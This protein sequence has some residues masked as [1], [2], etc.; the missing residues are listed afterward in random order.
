MKINRRRTDLEVGTIISLDYGFEIIVEAYDG[1]RDW[2]ITH[3]MDVTDDGDL[4]ENTTR[5]N[6]TTPS[7]LIGGHIAH[8]VIKANT[9]EPTFPPSRYEFQNAVAYLDREETEEIREWLG[10]WFQSFGDAHWTG[11]CWTI[12]SSRSLYPISVESR[13]RPGEF[14]TIDYEI[15]Q[16]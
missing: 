16:V 1:S 7:D 10:D 3:G 4:V 12:D 6:R 8:E 11:E 2:Y 5:K 13:T 15:R 14:I 9:W